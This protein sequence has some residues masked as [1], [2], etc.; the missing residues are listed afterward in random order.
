MK[1]AWVYISMFLAG[2]S[3]GIVIAVKWLSDKTV[4]KGDFRIR[5]RGRGNR[6]M[7]E[8]G[9]NL[10]IQT[11]RGDRKQSRIAKKNNRKLKKDLRKL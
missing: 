4:Y 8:L 11:K 7:T 2:L 6:Q 10:P 3:A 5:Q 9:L 1:K